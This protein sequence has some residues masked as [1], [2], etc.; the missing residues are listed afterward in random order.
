MSRA[1]SCLWRREKS[2]YCWN[3]SPSRSRATPICIVF[4][5]AAPICWR[6]TVPLVFWE[7]LREAESTLTACFPG[8]S[9]ASELNCVVET[10]WLQIQHHGF[11]PTL[12]L[13]ALTHGLGRGIKTWQYYLKFYVLYSPPHPSSPNLNHVFFLR[14]L[15][16]IFSLPFSEFHR[17]FRVFLLYHLSYT[18]LFWSGSFCVYFQC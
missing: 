12:P 10:G 2:G 13:A 3:H 9:R 17:N 11:V 4:Y 8:K 15:E 5:K 1:I 7:L 6:P 16:W 14:S 18:S